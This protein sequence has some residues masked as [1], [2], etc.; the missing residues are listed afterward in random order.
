MREKSLKRFALTAAA[1]LL[2][3]TAVSGPAYAGNTGFSA[4]AKLSTLGWGLE[5]NYNVHPM[6]SVGLS[7]NWWQDVTEGQSTFVDGATRTFVSQAYGLLVHWH[8]KADGLR[9]TLGVYKNNREIDY[10]TPDVSTGSNSTVQFDIN[11]N[12]YRGSQIGKV[13]GTL[14]YP[15]FAPYY[16]V[17]YGYHFN[18]KFGM[19]AELGVLVQGDPDLE[20]NAST[21]NSAVNAALQSEANS[22]KQDIEWLDK[23]PVVGLGVYYSF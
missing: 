19:L 11:G 10:A 14:T 16:G 4:G 6:F 17:G 20:L 1:G 8:P 12:G 9:L 13:T 3:I 23:Y 15:S 5:A 18:K 2:A 7:F 21:S 22:Y